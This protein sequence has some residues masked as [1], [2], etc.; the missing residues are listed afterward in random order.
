MRVIVT[1]SRKWRDV[2]IIAWELSKLP[3]PTTIVHGCATG[4]DAI[5]RSAAI[6]LGHIPEDHWPDYMSYDTN[7]APKLRNQE[8]VDAGADL[9]LAFP[10]PGSRGT[11]DC[12]ERAD[13]AGIPVTICHANG[14]REEY[15]ARRVSR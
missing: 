1:G 13:E 12:V 3:K 11:W 2:K 6:S 5:A 14:D 4:A 8:M 9:C 15:G 7:S 10:T